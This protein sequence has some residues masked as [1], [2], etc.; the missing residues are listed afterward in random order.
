MPVGHDVSDVTK[1]Y[2]M[3][4]WGIGLRM[5][6][7]A[8]CRKSSESED[9]QVLSID[10]QRDELERAFGGQPDI[11][12][13][14][15]FRESFSAKAPGRP[16]FDEMLRRLEQGQA[17]GILAW[18]PDRLARNS[19]DGG[20]II[21]LLD[22]KKLKDLKFATF[23]FENSPQ[24]KLMLSVLLGFSKYYVDS[25]SE[26]VKRGNRA[27]VERGWRPGMPPM[28]YRNDRENKTIVRDPEHFPVIKR[29]FELA[30]TGSHSWRDL[31]AIS[32]DQWGY[33]TPR[34]KRIGGKPLAVSTIYRLLSNPF[35]AGYFY[36][37]GNLYQGKHEPM[38]SLEEHKRLLQLVRKKG[39]A[40]PKT[41]TFPYVGLM[42]CGTCGRQITAERHIN[43]HGKEYVYYHCT[44]KNNRWDRCPE[45]SIEATA[46]EAQLAEFIGSVAVPEELEA[47]ILREGLTPRETAAA[48]RES[49]LVSLTRSREELGRQMTNLTDLRIGNYLPHAEFRERRERLELDLAALDKRIS[50]VDELNS[51]LEPAA[52][53]ISFSKCALPWLL[54]G[55]EET[56]RTIVQIVGSNP[57]IMDRK[58]SIEKA[59]PFV[60]LSDND[61][62]LDG[63]ARLNDV[64][65]LIQTKDPETLTVI[66]RIKALEDGKRSEIPA[67]LRPLG[68]PL[69]KAA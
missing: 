61:S 64:R 57:L 49:I 17:E 32:R 41:N 23:N 43:R 46:L 28:G 53:M 11:E 19:I 56:K 1:P 21:Y 47:L 39:V 2:G 63:R 40:H 24:G 52:S 51:W 15:V 27:K 68:E 26:N 67:V 34:H 62:N 66:Q 29:L 10:S 69:K 37:N 36:W 13:V 18:H 8:Y 22:I 33:R 3:L 9:R 7:F 65:T 31:C 4:D 55:D 30:L 54:H 20:R 35:Y 5:R 58:L 38:I 16:V 14:E 42:R 45:R 50:E 60:A 12:I 44:R 25:L 48:E 59:K 6:Y